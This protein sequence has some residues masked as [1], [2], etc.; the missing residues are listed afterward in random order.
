MKTEI[1][2]HSLSAPLFLF[3]VTV[4]LRALPDVDLLSRHADQALLRRMRRQRVDVLHGGMIQL[5]ENF[6][7]DHVPHVDE[8]VFGAADE[9]VVGRQDAG[10][11][12]VV[13]VPMAGV[14]EKRVVLNEAD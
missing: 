2:R 7:V 3:A 13:A 6:R 1:N 14:P 5:V 10:F 12:A 9:L 11:N 8:A 4:V